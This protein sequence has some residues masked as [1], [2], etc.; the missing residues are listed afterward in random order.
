MALRA[1]VY[2]ML[3]RGHALGNGGGGISGESG[4]ANP[5]L[6]MRRTGGWGAGHWSLPSGHVEELESPTAAAAREVLEEVGVA[7]PHHA[8]KIRHAMYRRSTA[9]DTDDPL[10]YLDLFFEATEWAGDPMNLEPGKCDAIEFVDTDIQLPE[11]TLPH[12]REALRCCRRN[13]PFTIETW[14]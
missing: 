1:A 4:S 14:P 11:R 2:V 6:M 13:I 3:R 10:V 5:M 8:L 7:V 9:S 12:V